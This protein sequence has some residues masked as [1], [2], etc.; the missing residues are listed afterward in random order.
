MNHNSIVSDICCGMR[1]IQ[2][3]PILPPTR[4]PRVLHYPI[5]SA[6]VV[7]IAD[8]QHCM[9]HLVCARVASRAKREKTMEN[10]Y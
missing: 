6:I 3:L 2:L 5:G 7:S 10:E 8:C 4:P 9:V 1:I